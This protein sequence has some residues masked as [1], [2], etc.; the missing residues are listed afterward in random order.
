M[1]PK[2]N[3]LNSRLIKLPYSILK[4]IWSMK[5]SKTKNNPDGSD[6]CSLCQESIYC[7]SSQ[8]KVRMD[9]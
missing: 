2:E 9:T 1:N 3:L 6:T 7:P 8:L 5:S 4:Y